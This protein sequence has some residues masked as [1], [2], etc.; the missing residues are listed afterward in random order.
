MFHY[1]SNKQTLTKYEVQSPVVCLAWQRAFVHAPTDAILLD[2]FF[3]VLQDSQFC[4]DKAGPF[5]F[6]WGEHW[7]LRICG[8]T[9]YRILGDARGAS[10]PAHFVQIS[11][12]TFR[13]LIPQAGRTLGPQPSRA[14][15]FEMC[16][17]CSRFLPGKRAAPT[18]T[19]QTQT[20]CS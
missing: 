12:H 10:T 13:T 5:L 8:K 20:P 3:H 1:V 6:S 15:N 4:L 11:A 7:V 19:D 17:V 16:E 14:S 18:S 9:I 2:L